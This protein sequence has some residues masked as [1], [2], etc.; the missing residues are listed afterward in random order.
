[1]INDK[2]QRIIWEG[3]KHDMKNNI[4][5]HE[6]EHNIAKDDMKTT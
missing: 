1:M 4:R 6:K 5:L 2:E 3:T